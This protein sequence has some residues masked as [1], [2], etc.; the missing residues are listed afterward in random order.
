MQIRDLLLISRAK[1]LKLLKLG[2]I[3]VDLEAFLTLLNELLSF[4]HIA[5]YIVCLNY[6]MN[7]INF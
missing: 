4:I 2:F 7:D 5:F 1:R 3:S 6:H